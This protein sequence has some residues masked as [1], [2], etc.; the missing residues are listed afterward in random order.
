M[1]D[2]V[3]SPSVDFPKLLFQL[4]PGIY[5]DKDAKGELR[6][7][8]EIV[9]LPLEEL[10]VSMAQLYEDLFIKNSR[11]PFIA[12][13]GALIGVEID[14]TL[15]DRA[16]RTEVEEAFAFYRSKGLHD[17]IALFAE[18][19]TDW[20]TT[21]LDFSQ[22][23][24]QVP[25]VPALNPVIPYR[26]QAVGEEPPGSG[27]FFFRADRERQ[28]LFDRVTGR[29]ITRQALIG[30]ESAYAGIEGRFAIRDRGTDLFLPDPTPSFTAVAADL[31]DFAN[32]KM[33]SGLALT[34]LPNQIAV[35]PELGRFKIVS[36]IP[37]AG[38]LKVDFQ[39]LVPASVAVQTFDLRDPN[40]I[41]RLNRSDDSAPHTL[42]IRRPRRATDR[43]GRYH[44]DNLGFFFT[45]GRRVRNQ[46]P[47]VLPPDSESG[48]FTFD[49][50]LPGLGET[51]GV[52]LQLQDG[53]DGSPLTRRKLE[54]EAGEYCGTTRGFT[55]RVSGIDLCSA[56]FQPA[57]TLRA[58]DLSDFT[59]PR[60]P[61]GA[62]LTLGPTDVAIDPQLGRFKLDLAGL[63]IIAEQIRVDYLL[64]PVQNHQGRSPAALSETVHEMFGFDPQGKMVV[65][66]D[67]EDGMP[68]SV[69]RRLGAAL[70]DFHGKR[71]GWTVYRNGVDVSG[72]LLQAEEK[73]LE[74]PTTPVTPGRLAVDL[75]RGRFK[76]PAGFFS[77]TDVIAV[78]YSDEE[79][80]AEAQLL[81]SF[82]QRSPRLLP[83]G[84]I[85]VPIDTRIVHVNPAVLT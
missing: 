80:D 72:V 46:R 38:N 83:A 25:F 65:L 56:D 58:A 60:T 4:L 44:F 31:I 32:P 22:K 66:R 45:F 61:A 36:P 15:P 76:F 17:P 50:R 19:V 1:S 37:L 74:D 7:F 10:E 39:V 35:D 49:G 82:L 26:G 24:A 21:V 20:R 28:P 55:I 71:R 42:D 34:I 68:I 63:G 43:F 48:N 77:P 12:L 30:Q 52:P 3:L 62:V 85:P 57:V 5:R 14:P 51:A 81:T 13:I 84:V 47:N 59:D 41:T 75:D 54:A 78:D 64:G 40:R 29:P 2:P 27:N 79:T 53:I 73:D 18:R 69:K 23:V 11:E 9:S 16:Q 6:R 8:L 67:G 33:P 70:A